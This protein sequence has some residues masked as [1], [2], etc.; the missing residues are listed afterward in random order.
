MILVD[1]RTGSAELLPHIIRLGVKAELSHLEFGDVCFEGKGPKGSIYVGVERKTLN[2]MLHCIDDS[3]YAAHQLP[4]MNRMYD[5]S[6]LA[7]EGIWACGSPPYYEGILMTSKGV[8]WFP[9]TYRT[10][11]VMYSKL[12]RYL[13]SISLSGVIITYSMDIIQTAA[14]IVN[15]FHYFQKRW[16]DHT[17]LLETQKLAIPDM[18]GK[19]SLVRR[20]AAELPGVGVKHSLDAEMRFKT[21]ANLARADETDWM[22]VP[23]VGFRTAQNIVKEINK[24]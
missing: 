20:W 10:R 7:L 16:E 24:R 17:S 23:G 21:A 22:S 15:S 2:D 5:K 6:F 13:I 11:R 12:Y 3:R 18:R 19:P 9:L 1:S 8:G 4:G 14:N